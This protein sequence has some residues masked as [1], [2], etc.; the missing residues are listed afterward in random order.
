MTR[1]LQLK[2][3]SAVNGYTEG[4]CVILTSVG[5]EAR[6]SYGDSLAESEPL[7]RGETLVLPA[8]LGA[9]RIEGNGVLL[10]SYV[11]DTNDEAWR[12]WWN[13]NKDV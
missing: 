3:Y 11:P 2:P 6:V 8:A 4:S 7:L 10:R 12:L 5:A 13:E 9:Y 1:E